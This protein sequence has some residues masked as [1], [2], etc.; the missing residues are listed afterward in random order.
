M[1]YACFKSGPIRWVPF[2]V[3]LLT[4]LIGSSKA[5]STYIAHVLNDLTNIIPLCDEPSWR[6]KDNQTRTREEQK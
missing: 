4:S 5:R 2:G 1:M 3:P 6:K